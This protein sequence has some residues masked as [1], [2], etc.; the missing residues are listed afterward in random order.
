MSAQVT[1]ELFVR[2]CLLKMAGRPNAEWQRTQVEAELTEAI[3]HTPGRREYL[4]G[5]TFWQNG[6]FV[7]QPL[8]GQSSANL[9]SLSRANSLLIVPEQATE[10]RAGQ[11]ISVLLLN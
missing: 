6:R 8:S 5:H 2:P 3:T 1:F 10:M 7:A 11:Q 9:Q 4:R